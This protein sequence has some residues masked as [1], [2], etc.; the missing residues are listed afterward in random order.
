MGFFANLFKKKE[1]KIA[2]VVQEAPVDNPECLKL[3][4]LRKYYLMLKTTQDPANFMK[5]SI[6]KKFSR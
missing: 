5:L 2:E 4:E 3:I 6:A 1:V